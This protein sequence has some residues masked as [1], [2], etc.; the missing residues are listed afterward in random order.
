MELFA[1]RR[2]Y[3]IGRRLMG[4]GGATA[5]RRIREEDMAAARQVVLSGWSA[6]GG[7]GQK[8]VQGAC[9]GNWRRLIQCRRWHPR[10]L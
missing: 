4:S 7:R 10:T 3:A 6:V 1:A 9:E 2:G 8:V 5:M